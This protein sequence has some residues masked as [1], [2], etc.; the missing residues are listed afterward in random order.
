MRPFSIN[1]RQNYVKNW[2]YTASIT[3]CGCFCWEKGKNKYRQEGC[4]E[5]RDEKDT[6]IRVSLS[7]AGLINF[8]AFFISGRL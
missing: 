8:L 5:M 2:S 7:L 6:V 3:S 4:R 1:V